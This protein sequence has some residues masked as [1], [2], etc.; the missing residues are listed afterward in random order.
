LPV[1]AAVFRIVRRLDFERVDRIEA[2]CVEHIAI[3]RAVMQK[4]G[5]RG[6]AAAQGAH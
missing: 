3:L 2:T 1:L 4:K 6:A 5:Q